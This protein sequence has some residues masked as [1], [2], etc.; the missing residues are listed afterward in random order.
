MSAR[1]CSGKAVKVTVQVGHRLHPKALL[2]SHCNFYKSLL[3]ASRDLA[4]GLLMMG[5]C[6][7]PRMDKALKNF[8]IGKRVLLEGC[9]VTVV[10]GGPEETDMCLKI[11]KVN[12]DCYPS[13]SH[14]EAFLLR[15]TYPNI[16][17]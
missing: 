4:V 11:P 15:T 13:T 14:H 9:Y 12:L 3:D 6:T 7:A 16:F 5:H 1:K 2:Y 10:Q 8:A 17:S